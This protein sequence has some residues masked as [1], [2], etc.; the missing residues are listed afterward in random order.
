MV[1]NCGVSNIYKQLLQMSEYEMSS[2]SSCFE[3]PGPSWWC[4]FVRF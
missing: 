2:K 1:D 3:R 4:Y